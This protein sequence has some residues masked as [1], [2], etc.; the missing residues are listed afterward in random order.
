MLGVENGAKVCRHER[1]VRMPSLEAALAY[2]AIFQRPVRELFAG[3]YEQIAQNVMVRAKTLARKT[4]RRPATR[5]N[6]RK[7]QTLSIIVEPPGPNSQST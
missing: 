6:T 4:A 5:V 7:Q 1:S 2:E 3:L